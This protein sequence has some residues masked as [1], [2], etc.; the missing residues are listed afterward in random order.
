MEQLTEIATGS[1]V[2]K[3]GAKGWVY[4][5]Q[6]DENW[7]ATN[8]FLKIDTNAVFGE[9]EVLDANNNYMVGLE[10]GLK[11]SVEEFAEVAEEITENVSS[12][13]VTF[14]EDV[15]IITGELVEDV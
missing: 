2:K 9:T 13:S 12:S 14:A 5:I 15:A 3:A 10:I 11:Q 7:Y 4:A 6:Y 1:M 8:P